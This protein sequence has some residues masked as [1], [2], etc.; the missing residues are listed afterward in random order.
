MKLTKQ[1]KGLIT[2]A[3]IAVLVTSLYWRYSRNVFDETQLN[4]NNIMNHMEELTSSVYGGRLAGSEG[5][6]KALDYI[7]TH[8][9]EIGLQPAGV[10]ETFFQPFSAL[11]PQIDP[12][13]IFTIINNDETIDK[14]FEMYRDYSVVMSP[15]GGS[16]LFQG[17][18]IVLGSDFLRVDPSKIKGRIAVIE[19]NNITP[20]IVTY[21]ME[22][23]GKGVL[24]SA[25][26]SSF[27]LFKELEKTKSLNVAGK[28]GDSILVG[29]ISTD[30][31]KYMQSTPEKMMKIKV[32]IDYPIVNTANVLGKIEGKSNNNSILLIS[33]DIDGLGVGTNGNHFPGAIN[34]TSGLAI[35]L[36]IARV[37]SNQE[38]LPF[39]TVIFAGWNGQK[40]QLSGSEFYANNALHP[41]DKTTIIHLDSIGKKTVMGLVIASDP[42]NGSIIRDRIMKY[43]IDDNLTLE[44]RSVAYGVITQFSDKKVPSV[45]LTDNSRTVDAY[46]DQIDNVDIIVIDNAAKILATF[47]KRDVFKDVRLDYLGSFERNLFVFLFLGGLISYII[48]KGYT[49]NSKLKIPGQTW[50]TLY[51]ST[52]NMLL[53]KFYANVF[54][55]LLAIFMLALLA[56]IDPD[57]DMKIINGENITNVSLYLSLKRS[58]VYIRN[59]L[60]VGVYGSD[61][62][63]NIFKVIYNSSKLSVAL[64]TVSL[65]LSTAVGILRGMYEAYR[66]R[67]S[68]LGSLGTLVF[69]SIPDVLIVLIVLLMYTGFARQFPSLKDMLQLKNFILPLFTLSIIPTIYISR[70][71]FITIQEELTKDYIKNEKAKGFS[72]KKIIF[73]ELLP[74]V[75]FRIVDAMPTI[76]TM[77]LSNMIVVEYLFNY[78]GIL[79]FLIY[80]Y[81]RQDVYRFVPLALTLGLIYIILT[82]GFQLLAKIINPMKRKEV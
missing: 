4:T 33:T 74:A 82:K 11:I 64:V 31:Y 47:I 58:I 30:T 20:R 32:E 67:K 2:I 79:Y 15:N 3:L 51:F 71:A 68:R 78:H 63:G 7:Q 16:T 17:E 27:G 9:Q 49:E 46:E 75:I 1:I 81:N 65:F 35:M 40:Q 23:G 52:P 34:N 45:L 76:V 56:N 25:D 50:E 53:R 73:I 69:F 57:A 59:M 21:I 18:Y 72:R 6:N 77:M 38:S 36:E 22:S 39:E 37:M 61:S 66:S 55:Y 42:V 10:D 13:P 5:N 29:Y 48:G 28:T 44:M 70:I 54:P 60:D 19:Y 26:S 14:S 41:L 43:A 24:C 80:L 62:V 8:F 12:E